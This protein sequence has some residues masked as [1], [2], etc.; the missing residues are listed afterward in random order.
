[1]SGNRIRVA[2]TRQLNLFKS[3]RQGGE[4][5]PSPLE[6]AV[7]IQVAEILRRWIN[8]GW[9]FTHVPLGEYRSISTAAK[10]K[11]MGCQAGWPDLIL[12]SPDR[13]V[14]FIEFKRASGGRMSAEQEAF[15]DWALG[16]GYPHLVTHDAREAVAALGEWGAIRTGICVQ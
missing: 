9:Q 3:K 15:R 11:R 7:H 5:A 8:V 14:F 6:L 4:L 1:M 12:L 16:H 2:G 13:A 10:L